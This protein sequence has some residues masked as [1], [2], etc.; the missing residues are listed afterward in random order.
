MAD[1]DHQRAIDLNNAV[2]SYTNSPSRIGSTLV[3]DANF[4]NDSA[5]SRLALNNE[6]L[7]IRAT[8]TSP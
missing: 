2:A 4:L 5:L 1:T 8:R 7:G 3:A 6:L